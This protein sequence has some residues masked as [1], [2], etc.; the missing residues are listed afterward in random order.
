MDRKKNARNNETISFP[1]LST[2]VLCRKKEYFVIK[3]ELKQI[4]LL[5]AYVFRWLG[6]KKVIMF[7]QHLLCASTPNDQYQINISTNYLFV[8]MFKRANR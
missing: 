2:L 7:L 6:F 3:S 4:I 1:F 5:I 8:A